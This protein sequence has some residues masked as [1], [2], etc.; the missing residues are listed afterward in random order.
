MWIFYYIS[1]AA[2][3]FYSNFHKLTAL[4][5]QNLGDAILQLQGT[6]NDALKKL[7]NFYTSCMNSDV[8]THT[9]SLM[10]FLAK[11]GEVFW[12]WTT[13]MKLSCFS[14]SVLFYIAGG[15]P[16]LGIS[17]GTLWSLNGNQFLQEKLLG[18]RA[19]FNYSVQIN[20]TDRTKRMIYVIVVFH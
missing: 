4:N 2:S 6:N 9:I 8:S 13:V 17:D 1:L 19:F 7:L 10:K 5:S 15:W 12:I 14:D 11:I 18:S 3:A 16:L 20:P